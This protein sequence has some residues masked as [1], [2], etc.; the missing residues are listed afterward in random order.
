[1]NVLFLGTV[2]RH[3]TT[4]AH[5]YHQKVIEAITEIKADVSIVSLHKL[6]RV[7]R[8]RFLSFLVPLFTAIKKRPSVVIQVSDTSP[9]YFI[10]SFIAW[11][12]GLPIIQIVHH[13]KHAFRKDLKYSIKQFCVKYSLKKSRRIIV[14]SGNTRRSAID[15]AGE[16]IREKIIIINPGINVRLGRQKPREY[17]EKR[18]W[19]ILCVGAVMKRKGYEY[20]LDALMNIEDKDFECRIA[21]NIDN[22][23]YYAFLNNKVKEAHLEEKVKFMGYVSDDDIRRLYA[24]A[25]IFVLPSLFEGFGMVLCEAMCYGLPIIASDVGAIPDLIANKENGLL[26]KAA[27]AQSLEFAIRTIMENGEIAEGLSRNA[28]ERCKNLKGWEEMK[29]QIVTILMDKGQ[30]KS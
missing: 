14:N 15:L 9:R 7:L 1:V 12:I 16:F 10:F 13:L 4:G 30:G 25:D 6:P 11:L 8:C 18:L 28:I 5:I 29:N 27:N 2:K 17:K 22:E 21:G 24:E 23:N 19:N 20:L 26:A 3:A